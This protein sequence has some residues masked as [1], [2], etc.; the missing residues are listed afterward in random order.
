MAEGT[1]PSLGAF[2]SYMIGQE[3][4][5][6]PMPPENDHLPVSTSLMCHFSDLRT[7]APGS[8]SLLCLDG[9]PMFSPSLFRSI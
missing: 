4:L 2:L 5:S 1:C 6:L 8:S 7:T 9:D 3:P